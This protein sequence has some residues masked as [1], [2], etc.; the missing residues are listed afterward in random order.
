MAISQL[1]PCKN[2]GPFAVLLERSQEL[3]HVKYAQHCN[4]HPFQVCDFL[5]TLGAMYYSNVLFSHLC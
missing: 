4:S 5:G 2:F 1:F 3:Y